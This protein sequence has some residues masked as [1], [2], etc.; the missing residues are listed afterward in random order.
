MHV[1]TGMHH[2]TTTTEQNPSDK[3]NRQHNPCEIDTGITTFCKEGKLKDT[4]NILYVMVQRRSP[5]DSG[6]YGPFL[7]GCAKKKALEEG[8]WVHA[9]LI[10]NGIDLDIF[11]E[12]QLLNMY[13]KCNS[14]DDARQLFD[15]MCKQN[16]VSWTAMILGYVQHGYFGEA[17]NLFSQMQHTGM[18]AN[19]FTFDSVISACASLA[20]LEHGKQIHAYTIRTGFE[21]NVIGAEYFIQ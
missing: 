10:K 18:D 20:A 5:V 6:S 2:T 21:S 1:F 7:Q 17:L 9:H 8:R 12:N 11:A 13:A 19:Q 15:K 4:K 16:V 3:T 14:F